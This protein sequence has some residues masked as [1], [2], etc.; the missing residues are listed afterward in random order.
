MGWMSWRAFLCEID[1]DAH[2]TT[3]IN[4][5]LYMQM[6][7]RLGW[8]I[9]ASDPSVTDGYRDAGYVSVHLD[10]CWMANKRD[11]SGTLQWNATRFPSGMPALGDYVRFT[12]LLSQLLFHKQG[13]KFGIYEDVGTKTCAGYPGSFGYF[14]VGRLSKRLQKD[15]NTFA[16]WGVDYLKFDGCYISAEDIPM[17]YKQ[18]GAALNATGRPIVY[19]CSWPLFALELNRTDIVNP[20]PLRTSD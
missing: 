17:S 1:C 8:S 18:M 2:P 16:S 7:D 5:Q 20:F 3:C 4:E 10:D 9:P 15:A 13:L 19:G 11:S 12:F 6:A 14:E